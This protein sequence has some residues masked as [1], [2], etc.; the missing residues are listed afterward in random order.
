MEQWNGMEWNGRTHLEWNSDLKNGMEW[1]G[2]EW[3]G[4]EWN[5]MEWNGMDERC[6]FWSKSGT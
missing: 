2:M 3:N 4:M 1:N 5:G 6:F